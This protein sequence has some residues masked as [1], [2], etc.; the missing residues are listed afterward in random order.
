M[1]FITPLATPPEASP[2]RLKSPSNQ[3][4]IREQDRLIYGD[5]IQQTFNRIQYDRSI[6]EAGRQAL[7]EKLVEQENEYEEFFGKGG[8]NGK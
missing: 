6:D 3:T 1:N 4:P 5:A 2:T 7:R 8:E